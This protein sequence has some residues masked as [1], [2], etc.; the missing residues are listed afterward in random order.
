ML[1]IILFL[2]LLITGTISISY[3]FGRFDGPVVYLPIQVL[4]LKSNRVVFPLFRYFNYPNSFS[5]K[6]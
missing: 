2:S 5:L 3:S 4:L 6:W 1:T